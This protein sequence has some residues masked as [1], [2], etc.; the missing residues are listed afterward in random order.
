MINKNYTEEIGLTH[1]DSSMKYS[2]KKVYGLR[3]TEINHDQIISNTS[4]VE[5]TASSSQELPAWLQLF[6][7][8]RFLRLSGQMAASEVLGSK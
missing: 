2:Q 8:G 5:S 7:G 4:T 3:D 6:F 1:S